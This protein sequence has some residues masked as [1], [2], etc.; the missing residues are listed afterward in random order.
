MVFI[1]ATETIIITIICLRIKYLVWITGKEKGCFLFCWKV[2][3]LQ[4]LK[5]CKTFRF[6]FKDFFFSENIISSI[7]TSLRKIH[8]IEKLKQGEIGEK[9]SYT[10]LT[11]KALITACDCTNDF[12]QKMKNSSRLW[13]EGYYLY[14]SNN[15]K[16]TYTFTCISLVGAN[17]HLW[18][19]RTYTAPSPFGN[20]LTLVK[21]NPQKLKNLSTHCKLLRLQFSLYKDW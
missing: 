13:L 16:K 18:I 10:A 1:M 14:L 8:L 7:K 2:G 11:E 6:P 3:F 21:K 15:L 19:R 5:I 12:S 9:K 4:N 20:P 17:H